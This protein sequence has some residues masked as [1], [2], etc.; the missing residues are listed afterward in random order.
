V[1]SSAPLFKV[2]LGT[3][4]TKTLTLPPIRFYTRI[5]FDPRRVRM[6]MLKTIRLCLFLIIAIPATATGA[7]T[8][9]LPQR[10]P[11]EVPCPQ[12][13]PAADSPSAIEPHL[14][15]ARTTRHLG[16]AA[17]GLMMTTL[18]ACWRIHQG[19]TARR[20]SRHVRRIPVGSSHPQIPSPADPH[21][22]SNSNSLT[23]HRIRRYDYD[24]FYLHML[25]DL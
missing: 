11:I 21:S 13:P 15:S 20:R 19:N 25:R 8:T 1:H 3:D 22:N 24:R 14:E 10:S 7:H 18:G 23:R 4:R 6:N 12:D 16:L 9:Q 5:E 17:L 2:I